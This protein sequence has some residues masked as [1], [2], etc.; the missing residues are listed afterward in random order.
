MNQVALLAENVQK[1][2]GQGRTAVTAVQNVTLELHKGEILLIMGPSGSGKTTLLSMLG[3]LL[4]PSEGRIVVDG[5]DISAFSE[6]KLPAIR[7]RHFGFIFQDFNLL[8]ALTAR[9]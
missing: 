2:F 5:V 9:E 7:L 6:A 8:S 1:R 3:A 4:R